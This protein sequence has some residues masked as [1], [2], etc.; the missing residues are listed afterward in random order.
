MEKQF[1]FLRHTKYYNH[2]RI[3]D[4]KLD[5]PKIIKLSGNWMDHCYE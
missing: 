3:S 2:C 5:D 1:K 4:I